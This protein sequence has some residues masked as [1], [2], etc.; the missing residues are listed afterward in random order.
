MQ[1]NTIGAQYLIDREAPG[2]MAFPQW[3]WSRTY[4][5]KANTKVTKNKTLA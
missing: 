5:Q 4:T 2:A 3:I 1:T